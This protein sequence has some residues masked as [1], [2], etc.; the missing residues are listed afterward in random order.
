MVQR[1]R[2]STSNAGGWVTSLVDPHTP[3]GMTRKIKLESPSP[4]HRLFLLFCFLLSTRHHL[5]DFS[6]ESAYLLPVPYLGCKL[7]KGQAS[8]GGLL[9]GASPVPVSLLTPRL[10]LLPR[11]PDTRAPTLAW[12]LP[13]KRNSQGHRRLLYSDNKH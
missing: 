13:M 10:Q 7:Q 3:R 11:I 5:T 2:L 12:V 8:V 9:T 6:M 1:L 4:L